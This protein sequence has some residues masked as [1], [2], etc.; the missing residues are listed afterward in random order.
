MIVHGKDYGLLRKLKL[1][2]ERNVDIRRSDQFSILPDSI[3]DRIKNAY[4][5]Y[6]RS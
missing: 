2:E 1:L 4:V 6:A 3:K 5:R